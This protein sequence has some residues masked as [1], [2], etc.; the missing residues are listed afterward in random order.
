M[1]YDPLTDP[2]NA[3]PD[4]GDTTNADTTGGG[5]T[6][7]ISS[8]DEFTQF[9]VSPNMENMK[10]PFTLKHI[11]PWGENIPGQTEGEASEQAGNYVVQRDPKSFIDAT[12]FLAG[13][14][15]AAP[16]Q[17]KQIQMTLVAGGF[18]GKNPDIRPGGLDATTRKAWNEVLLEAMRTGK[19]P[20]EIMSAAVDAAGGL[21]AG[22]ARHGLSGRSV[23]DIHWMHP[24]DIRAVAKQVSMKVLG[25]SWNA[26]QLEHF[27]QTYQGMQMTAG[28]TAQGSG[29]TVTEAPS[30]ATAAEAE[31]RRQNPVEAGATDWDN[32][33][34]GIATAIHELG[35]SAK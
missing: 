34:Q 21:D 8:F 33:F 2:N 24:D 17:Y 20:D 35:G 13:I 6:S 11:G 18:A 26:A 32:A 19:T 31:A 10:V 22:L 27:V 30:L 28:Q 14:N 16:D 4:P 12:R 3:V 1:P 29:A 5:I 7:A 23:A 15:T 9:G 25:K